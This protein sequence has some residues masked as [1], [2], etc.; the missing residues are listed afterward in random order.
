MN[1]ERDTWKDITPEDATESEL[2]LVHKIF[3]PKP[4]WMTDANW[5]DN[6]RAVAKD[7]RQHVRAR[8]VHEALILYMAKQL[9][10]CMERCNELTPPGEIGILVPSAEDIILEAE[11]RFHESND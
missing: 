8:A 2:L 7:I 3:G 6:M 1:T 5:R 10:A 9:V 4:K 11:M